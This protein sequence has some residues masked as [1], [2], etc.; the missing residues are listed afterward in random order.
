MD[1][2]LRKKIF[3]EVISIGNHLI[4]TAEKDTNGI[5]WKTVTSGENFTVKPLIS[6]TVYNGVS[7]IAIFL[8]DLYKISLKEEY[9]KYSEKAMFWVFEYCR[10]NNSINYGLYTGRASVIFAAIRFYKATKDKK[11]LNEALN[12]AEGIRTYNPPDG[13]ND[14]IGGISGTILSLLHL[15]SCTK[16]KWLLHEIDRLTGILINNINIG[17]KGGIYWD[18]LPDFVAGLCGFSH[19]ASGIAFVFMELG[20]YFGNRAFYHLAELAFYYED[21]HF[22][23]VKGNWVDLRRHKTEAVHFNEQKK[24]FLNDNI[25]YF[26]EK[27]FM[28]A[29][30]HGAAGIG[31]ARM[32]AFKIIRKIQYFKNLLS[33]IKTTYDTDVADNHSNLLIYCHGST[34]NADLFLETFLELNEK[35][36]LKY[37]EI[38]G[39]KVLIQKQQIG[40]Y[41]SGYG[42]F[43]DQNVDD[44]SMLMGMSGIGHFFTRLLSPKK[45]SSMLMP[46]LDSKTKRETLSKKYKH[47][48]ININEISEILYKKLYPKTISYLFQTFQKPIKFDEFGVS[49]DYT[50][51]FNVFYSKYKKC[52]QNK[53]ISER[54]SDLFKYETKYI[55]FDHSIMSF[56]YLDIKRII[57]NE[58]A[59]KFLKF[60][61]PV[62]LKQ[63]LKLN[64]S[65]YILNSKWDWSN[66]NETLF[67][68]M[69]TP[70]GEIY[71]VLKQNA[72][73][74]IIKKISQLVN[75][76]LNSFQTEKTVNKVI[77]ELLI[78]F[79]VN[80]IKEKEEAEKILLIQIK[81]LAGSCYLV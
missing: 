12:I 6:E 44:K 2:K 47:I 61:D 1:A 60:D 76:I 80:S 62:F 52:I 79:D 32:R 10:N 81:E 74:T 21:Q 43:I 17:P 57:E 39:E 75:I 45:I 40:Y 70:A 8:L 11:Y 25:S 33:A 58:N 67:N 59:K 55:Q 20:K 19:G 63:S 72:N 27:R 41:K 34:G 53:D 38:V 16:K 28:N 13:L 7:G 24:H 18:R 42:V 78:C 36:Y 54:L 37:A 56:A 46:K 30:C 68:M 69:N 77:K 23:K 66:N 31:L 51:N 35:K 14:L 26:T 22:D 48:N 29:W 65:I 15:H 73:K 49:P 64:N 71:F 9:L 50:K 5:Y 3:D 4:E